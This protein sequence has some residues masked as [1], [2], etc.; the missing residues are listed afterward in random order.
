MQLPI[1]R[2]I[3]PVKKKS[4]TAWVPKCFTPDCLRSTVVIA[5][6]LLPGI[7]IKHGDN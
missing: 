1:I 5:M 2:D 6:V 3:T 4:G 7:S